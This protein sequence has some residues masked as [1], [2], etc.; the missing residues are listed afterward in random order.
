MTLVCGRVR[1]SLRRGRAAGKGRR[2][3]ASGRRCGMQA[4]GGAVK[5]MKAGVL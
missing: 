2:G 3:G 4:G 1:H 5:P